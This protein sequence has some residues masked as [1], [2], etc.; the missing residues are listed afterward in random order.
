MVEVY[1]KRYPE[2]VRETKLTHKNMPW[3]VK[4][5]FTTLTLGIEKMRKRYELIK[6]EI[7]EEILSK[8]TPAQR[9]KSAKYLKGIPHKAMAILSEECAKLDPNMHRVLQYLVDTGE[10]RGVATPTHL[11]LPAEDVAESISKI[12]TAMKLDEKELFRNYPASRLDTK[13]IT[14]KGIGEVKIGAAIRYG[15]E[16]LQRAVRGSIC[17]EVQSC[18]NELQFLELRR[19]RLWDWKGLEV[20]YTRVLRVKKRTEIEFRLKQMVT[21]LSDAAEK[22]SKMMALTRDV[23][24]TMDEAEALISSVAVSYTLGKKVT[25]NIALQY[26]SSERTLWDLAMAFTRIAS[27]ESLFKKNGERSQARVSSAGTV[28]LALPKKKLVAN[29]RKFLK[30]KKIKPI[31][32]GVL[33]ALSGEE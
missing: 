6:K 26:L 24:L 2:F 16:F 12:V 22:F 17:I 4:W 32:L 25:K 28:L 7:K 29:S 14:V 23:K 33:L 19:T 27:D 13:T 9:R 10:I 5:Q 30:K 11:P 31:D 3:V 1:E 8:L 15:H 20:A 18:L 21:E